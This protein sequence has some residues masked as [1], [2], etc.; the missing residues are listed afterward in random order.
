[1]K[2]LLCVALSVAIHSG[3]QGQMT[4]AATEFLRRFF[5]H[6]LPKGSYASVTSAFWPI[7]CGIPAWRWADNCLGGQLYGTIPS[8]SVWNCHRADADGRDP[9]ERYTRA[10][11]RDRSKLVRLSSRAE[12]Q[13][14]SGIRAPNLEAII[15]ADRQTFEPV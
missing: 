8:G 14:A 15:F 7:A 5:L 4:L 11:D 2:L 12:A 6:V 9:P 1:M 13:Q 3:K 10:H